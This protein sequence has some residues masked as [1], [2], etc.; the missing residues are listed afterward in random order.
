MKPVG[1][2]VIKPTPMGRGLAAGRESR[3][4]VLVSSASRA[5]IWGEAAEK[6]NPP[7]MKPGRLLELSRKR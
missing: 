5:W 6:S 7:P 3:E 2:N 1:W 4:R